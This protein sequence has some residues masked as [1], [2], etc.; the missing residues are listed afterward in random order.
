MQSIYTPVKWPGTSDLRTWETTDSSTPSYNAR[1]KSSLQ[2]LLVLAVSASVVAQT[3]TPSPLGV[4]VKPPQP[5]QLPANIRSQLPGKAKVRLD[6]S[7]HLAPGGETTLVY[8]L[9]E[10]GTDAHIAVIK[11]GK[12]VADLHPAD[13]E[14]YIFIQ[15]AESQEPDGQHVL[16][17]A[18]QSLG[19]GSGTMFALIT[20]KDGNYRIAWT[21]ETEQGSF[22]EI[23][24]GKVELWNG[25]GDGSCVW[26]D[27]HYT[28]TTYV[29]RDGTLHALE[30][31]V[32]PRA[33]SPYQ[34]SV[35]AIVLAK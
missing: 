1:M 7:T 13:A 31:H 35:V 19:D 15:A 21:E 25:K 6:A 22:K 27:E 23:G 9:G 30:H 8:D 20:E 16:I 32:A 12:R 10:F 14:D 4:L 28:V 29:W 3:R 18:F 34:V 26:C 11:N 24:S 2:L 17:F 5:I 33:M